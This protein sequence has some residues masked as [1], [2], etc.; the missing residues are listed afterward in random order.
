MFA[1]DFVLISETP[2]GL[3]KQIEKALE[4]NRIWRVTA[5]VRKCAVVVCSEDKVN[6]VNFKW[7][8]GE[9][10]LPIVDQYT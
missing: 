4:Y 3:Q 10:D 9:D 5:N 6:P 1:D 7:K 8:W 2:E